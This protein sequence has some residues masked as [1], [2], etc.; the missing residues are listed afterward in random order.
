MSKLTD[1]ELVERII[2]IATE[3]HREMG[4]NLLETIYGPILFNQLREAELAADRNVRVSIDYEGISIPN[5]FI[6]D[7]LVEDRIILDIR[8]EEELSPSVSLHLKN[9]LRLKHLAQGLILNFGKPTMEE[10]IHRVVHG[11]IDPHPSRL[12]GPLY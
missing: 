8:S 1:Q 9:Y 12:K 7:I 4:P 5:A 6:I 10:G 11:P 3:I 2:G